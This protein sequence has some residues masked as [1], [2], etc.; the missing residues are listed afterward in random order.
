MNN[1]DFFNTLISLLQKPSPFLFIISIVTGAL[2]FLKDKLLDVLFLSD[3]RN[4]YAPYIGI[5]FLLTTLLLIT[6]FLIWLYLEIAKKIKIYIKKIQRKKILM[7]LNQEQFE[8]VVQL[9]YRPGKCANLDCTQSTVFTLEQYLIIGRSN[10]SSAGLYFSYFLQPWVVEYID[11]HKNFTR[12]LPEKH[13]PH[14]F[15]I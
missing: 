2:L 10:L 6:Y 9:Y 12:N 1:F 11:K 14:E 7:N 8:T 13:V 3:F 15:C 4:Q 5:I